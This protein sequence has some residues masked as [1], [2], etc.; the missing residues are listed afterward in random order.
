MAVMSPRKAAA[1]R[2]G[3]SLYDLLVAAAEKMIATHG[4]ANLT[5]REIARTAGV[6]D[7][8]L[9]NHF[10]DK[11]ELVARALMAHVRATERTLGDL[12]AAGEGSL[13]ENLHRY[14]AFGLALHRVIVPA[15]SGLTGRPEVLRR[16]SEIGERSGHWRDQL[17]AY[18]REERTLGR[19]HPESEVDAAAAL[20][21]GYCH[22]SVL[23]KVF[24]HTEQPNPPTAE[25][26]VKAVLNGIA[27]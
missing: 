15:F 16:F 5:V 26:I 3:Q 8:V 27:P 22:E 17:V 11:E 14:L 1:Q 10:S 25:S 12:P 9:Y 13:T 2:D 23:G 7:G 20:L 21:V 19:L 6:A 18:L 24:P 4:T